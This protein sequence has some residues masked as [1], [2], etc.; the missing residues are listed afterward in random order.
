MSRLYAG[1]LFLFAVVMVLSLACASS[2]SPETTA[3]VPAP[4][5]T[6]VPGSET[7]TVTPGPTYSDEQLATRT[8]R[9]ESG[10]RGRP[11]AESFRG[12]ANGEWELRNGPWGEDFPTVT[13]QAA[14]GGSDFSLELDCLPPE[15]QTDYQVLR[16]SFTQE[17]GA[18][19]YSSNVRFLFLDDAGA[20]I[21]SL[22]WTT[23]P[24]YPKGVPAGVQRV[25]V[26]YHLGSGTQ[27]IIDGLLL[28]GVS[29][30]KLEVNK[31]QDRNGSRSYMLN[32]ANFSNF[33]GLLDDYCRQT[34]D[35]TLAVVAADVLRVPTSTPIPPPTPTPTPPVTFR[36]EWC[37]ERASR[38]ISLQIER[39][40]YWY[41]YGTRNTDMTARLIMRC[42]GGTLVAGIH[43]IRS[44]G[45]YPENKNGIAIAA[46]VND[47][48]KPYQYYPDGWQ[49]VQGSTE[50]GLF[51]VFPD[52]VVQEVISLIGRERYGGA[53]RLGLWV[54]FDAVPDP[55]P[56]TKQYD[57]RLG[58]DVVLPIRTNL[59]G[60]YMPPNYDTIP[61]PIPTPTLRPT[62]TPTAP[63]TPRWQSATT[64]LTA[65]FISVPPSHNGEDTIGFRL[66]F[67][68]PVSTSYK[69][70]RDV[71]IRVENGSV[72]ESK[73]VDGRSDLWMITVEPDGN[74]DMVV[75]LTA[76]A[77]CDDPA[78]VCTE[79]GK[80]LANSPTVLVRY[81]Q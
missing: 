31:N 59:S 68:E 49:Q 25:Y 70:L 80:A 34:T 77:G 74:D 18:G 54:L 66:Q 15:Q 43:V 61:T 57:Q 8:S 27:T 38:G 26:I 53:D 46:L 30:V 79:G 40:G 7:A 11:L 50:E 28:D 47:N 81:G 52:E 6:A 23:L 69:V 10:E 36:Q 14:E 75:T 4:E 55:Q 62:P 73:R 2:E 3:P 63:P 19:L 78:S 37:Q 12:R 17:E 65:E 58:T 20:E 64:P 13:L 76:P 39:K 9:R 29:Q 35:E 44:D 72:A 21:R 5:L 71:A 1:F 42:A 48:L 16:L 60:N 41:G 45:E 51:V 67:T 22:G 56:A 32:T 24:E 33:H